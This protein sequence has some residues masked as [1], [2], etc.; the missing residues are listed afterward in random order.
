MQPGHSPCNPSAGHFILALPRQE[1]LIR[2]VRPTRAD[3]ENSGLLANKTLA[4]GNM[5]PEQGAQ[6]VSIAGDSRL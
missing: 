1:C 4:L 3:T 5:N 2:L 6:R